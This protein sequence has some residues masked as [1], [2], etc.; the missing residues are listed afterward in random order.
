[1]IPCSYACMNSS[2]INSSQMVW[3][4]SRLMCVKIDADGTFLK[5]CLY[6]S[7]IE[8]DCVRTI[9]EVNLI[10]NRNIPKACMSGG[11]LQRKL[12]SHECIWRGFWSKCRLAIGMLCQNLQ[13]A[14]SQNTQGLQQW[15][16]QGYIQVPVVAIWAFCVPPKMRPNYTPLW[17]HA[18]EESL[19][20][21]A[22]TF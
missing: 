2:S 9:S 18:Q 17:W 15:L 1:M 22:R 3:M 13:D 16:F 19:G 20:M 6:A 21:H 4:S 10:Q 12:A 11:E 14:W 7:P 8:S 5:T